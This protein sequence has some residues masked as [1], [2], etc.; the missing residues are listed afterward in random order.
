MSPRPSSAAARVTHEPDD[1]EWPPTSDELS[2]YDVGP[3]PWQSV[4][5]AAGDAQARRRESPVRPAAAP[6]VT[7]ILTRPAVARVS[8][9]LVAAITGAVAVAA[10]VA[11]W[12]LFRSTPLPVPVETVHHPAPAAET[13]APPRLK[14][15]A[16]YQ[17]DPAASTA[18]AR[19]QAG[20]GPGA[21]SAAPGV[22]DAPGIPVTPAA[23]Q[24]ALAGVSSIDAPDAPIA[25]AATPE[26]GIR[27]LLRR[28]EDAYDRRDVAAAA[29]LW[30]SLD[31]PALT[32]AFD[33][34][35]AQDVHFDRCQIDAS[36]VRGSAVCVGTVRYR[37]AVGRG[38]E[39]ADRITWT[40]DLARSGEDWRIDGLSAR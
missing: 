13:K 30:P 12:S 39:R 36:A 31:R 10:A 25:S 9:P 6:R 23:T 21:S 24:H 29:A 2:V 37:R 18:A 26:D 5:A 33:G 14:F 27:S 1:F 34:L 38:G 7:G 3:D 16:T 28:Y 40:F 17:V 19:R 15:V 35:A 20:A 8:W 11:G 32:R 22:V 4:H